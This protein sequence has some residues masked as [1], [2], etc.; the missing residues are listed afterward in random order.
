VQIPPGAKPDAHPYDFVYCP[1]DHHV[2]RHRVATMV[3]PGLVTCEYKAPPG[4]WTPSR[5]SRSRAGGTILRDPPVRSDRPAGS[6]EARAAPRRYGTRRVPGVRT[7]PGVPS[8]RSA[9]RRRG[10]AV[11][12]TRRAIGRSAKLDRTTQEPGVRL[13]LKLGGIIARGELALPVMV[14]PLCPPQRLLWVTSRYHSPMALAPP[15][16]ETPPR[17]HR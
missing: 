6:R 9:A 10:R 1:H 14:G 3:E 15:R 12:G 5:S 17:R 13:M 11:A 4:T 7:A 16:S 2:P 8:P